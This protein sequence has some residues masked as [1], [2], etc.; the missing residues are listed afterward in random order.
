MNRIDITYL[1]KTIF[2]QEIVCNRGTCY[3]TFDQKMLKK[4]NFEGSYHVTLAI[5]VVLNCYTRHLKQAYA[6]DDTY[7][8]PIHIELFKMDQRQPRYVFCLNDAP[9]MHHNKTINGS[10]DACT[11][12]SFEMN[13]QDETVLLRSNA[14]NYCH[15]CMAEIK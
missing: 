13:V 9:I 11:R 6:S 15:C 7:T 8:A 1:H 3:S 5:A 12:G 10:S 2:N 4:Y 14:Q